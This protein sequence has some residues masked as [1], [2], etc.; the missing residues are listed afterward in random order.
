MVDSTLELVNAASTWKSFSTNY[1]SL[2][3]SYKSFTSNELV[4]LT[5]YKPITLDTLTTD[6]G[7]YVTGKALDGL[8]VVVGQEELKIRQ[9]PFSY[10]ANVGE[11]ILEE[12]FGQLFED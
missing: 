12:I 6:L 10:A 9:D 2:L 11:A 7:S 3:S 5:S 1:N 4:K 8:F